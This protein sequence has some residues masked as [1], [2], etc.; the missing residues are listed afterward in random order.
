MVSAQSGRRGFRDLMPGQGGDMS[1]RMAPPCTLATRL[2]AM[3]RPESLRTR[4]GASPGKRL[5]VR[6]CA[7]RGQVCRS[8]RRRAVLPLTRGVIGPYVCAGLPVPTGALAMP[9][10]GRRSMRGGAVPRQQFGWRTPIKPHIDAWVWG[11]HMGAAHA[12]A[13]RCSNTLQA[14]R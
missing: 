7:L 11:M 10:L 4:G 3:G 8:G 13:I 6:R 12:V 2:A 5:R 14:S 1:T 9:R